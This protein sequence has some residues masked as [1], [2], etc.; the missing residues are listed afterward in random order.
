M[1]KGNHIMKALRILLP[2]LLL[3]ATASCTQRTSYG[4]CVGITDEGKPNLEYKLSA[5]NTVVAIFFVETLVVPVVYAVDD[6]KCP[7]GEKYQP[8][9]N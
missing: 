6:A 1:K 8:E 7:V 2:I 9:K 5:W 4:E 3:L